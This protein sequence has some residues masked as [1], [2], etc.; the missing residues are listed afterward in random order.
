[1]Q[2][3]RRGQR[4]DVLYAA[5]ARPVP[6]F[7]PHKAVVQSNDAGDTFG[8]FRVWP[9]GVDTKIELASVSQV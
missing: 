2:G 5:W 9:L 6:G 8:I 4:P 3:C 7:I 1:M